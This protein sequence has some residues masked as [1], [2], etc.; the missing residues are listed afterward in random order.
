MSSLQEHIPV[1]DF[2][3]SS[4][5]GARTGEHEFEGTG[6]LRADCSLCKEFVKRG[7]EDCID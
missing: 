3:A 1:V 4:M 6:T 7:T 5:D 2:M